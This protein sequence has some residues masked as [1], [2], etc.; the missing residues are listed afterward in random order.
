MKLHNIAAAML[1]AVCL[2]FGTTSCLDDDD[3][4]V[5]T[6]VS[7][8]ATISSYGE[9]LINM[10]ILDVYGKT[11]NIYSDI[12]GRV[13]KEKYPVGSRAFITYNMNSAQNTNVPFKVELLS[14]RPTTVIPTIDAR[15]A[16]CK[17]DYKSFRVE[18]N[19]L[20]GNFINMVATVERDPDRSWR[21]LLD[22]DNSKGEVAN[23]YLLTS[24]PDP[25]YTGTTAVVCIDVESIVANKSYK[26]I[27]LHLNNIES[28]NYIYK[29]QINNG[30]Q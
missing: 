6:T 15:N 7:D 9:N 21:C 23:L 2:A 5:T 26:E 13:D 17:L 3:S 19:Y 30:K 24:A 11:Y 25:E 10:Q 8:I 20:A 29:F 12:N 16:E 22:T 27:H 28:Q 14:I 4:A 18:R 1:A